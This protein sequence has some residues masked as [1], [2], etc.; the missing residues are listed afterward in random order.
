MAPLFVDQHGLEVDILNHPLQEVMFRAFHAFQQHMGQQMAT[1]VGFD[2]LQCV[3]ARTTCQNLKHLT[4]DQKGLMRQ[5]MIGAFITEDHL[6]G[7]YQEP[8]EQRVCKFCGCSD[9]IIHRHWECVATEDSR[10]VISVESRQLIDNGFPCLRERAWAVEPPEVFL[11]RQAL[12]NITDTTW[13]TL[14][15]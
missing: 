15:T 11:F 10:K 12:S 5:L 3:D 6:G 9:S 13:L 8:T 2:G 14:G 1:R 4:C 7:A